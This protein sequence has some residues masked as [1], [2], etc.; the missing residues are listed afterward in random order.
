MF[1]R[2]AVRFGMVGARSTAV[3]TGVA[4]PSSS[5]MVTEIPEIPFCIQNVVIGSTERVGDVTYYVITVFGE[6]G[7]SWVVKQRF[8]AFRNLHA[9]LNSS[10]YFHTSMANPL[11]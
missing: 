8:D 10:C 4:H 1:A 5:P 2:G 11:L 7:A 9:E 6:D 3:W